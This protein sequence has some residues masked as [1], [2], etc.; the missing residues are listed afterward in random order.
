LGG[1]DWEFTHH[2]VLVLAEADAA[3]IF[4]SNVEGTEDEFG[5]LQVDGVADQGVD[6]FHEGGLDRFLI[7]DEGDRVQAGVGR[8]RV[9]D[10]V[11][12]LGERTT[13]GPIH[14]AAGHRRAAVP[15]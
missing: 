8:S 11:A 2:F 5:A 15:T 10:L 9:R 13:C 4:Y 12:P 6:D 3:D 14:L 1:V 7:L